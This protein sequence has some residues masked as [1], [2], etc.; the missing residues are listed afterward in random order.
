MNFLDQ[1]TFAASSAEGEELLKTVIELYQREPP[2]TA[3]VRAVNLPEAKIDFQ[4]PV[5]DI[6]PEVLL[7][8]AQQ[9]KLR[10]L[11]AKVAENP[12]SQT[13]ADYFK[14]VLAPAPEP[15]V[16]VNYYAAAILPARRSLIDRVDL[17]NH[18]QDLVSPDGSRVFVVSGPT[19]LGKSHTWLFISF[20]AERTR[21]F[22]PYLVD[23]SRRAGSPMTAREVAA[24][25]ATQ[26]GWDQP[27]VSDASTQGPTMVRMLV[28]W[29]TGQA[30]RLDEQVWF[31]FDG[32]VDETADQYAQDLLSEITI[33]ANKNVTPNVR[34]S[35]LEFDRAL[36]PEVDIYAAKEPLHRPSRAD[37]RAFFRAAAEYYRTA[38]DD[39]G[40][41][42][43]V[44][45]LLG[46]DG[47]GDHLSLAELGAHASRL[48]RAAFEVPA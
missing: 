6:W 15:D 42:V 48:A 7:V 33:A 18:L 23:A 19:G 13:A 5:E 22:T 30:R 24:D 20:L 35:L 10:A 4:Q 27:P 16:T 39:E 47:A 37:C 29:F 34:V 17:R 2:V 41:E 9:N 14:R 38:V 21:A 45:Q 32:F 43:L 1:R 36:D 11:I 31:V 40:L 25:I 3:F 12:N 44:T 46:A 28:A 26:L 8:A